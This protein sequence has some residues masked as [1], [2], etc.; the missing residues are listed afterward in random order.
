MGFVAVVVVVFSILA[1]DSTNH[2]PPRFGFVL[3]FS[4]GDQ[5]ARTN[6]TF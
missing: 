1:E 4:S 2:S 3:F 6:S 5:F